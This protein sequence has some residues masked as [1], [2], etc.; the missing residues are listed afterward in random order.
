MA[1]HG[2]TPEDLEDA[3]HAG[4]IAPLYLFYGEEDYLIDEA[5]ARL[6][7]ASLPESGR[8]FNLDVLSGTDTDARDIVAR[9]SAF[10]MVAERRIVIVREA[11]RLPEKGLELLAHY[12]EKPSPS[13][14]LVL[15]AAKP[16]M[17]RRAF[18]TIKRS[19]M[20]FEFRPLYENQLPSWIERRARVRK[21][22]ITLEAAKLLVAYVG[23]SLRDL[24]NEL[25]KVFLYMGDRLAITEDDVA[26][27][28]GFTREFN[29][30]EL[31]RAIG[32][33][34]LSRA[35]EVMEKMLDANQPMPLIVSVLTNYFSTLWKIGDL[36]RR[37]TKQ[38]DLTGQVRMNPYFLKEYL[39]TLTV[40]SVDEI[41]GAFHHLAIVD[42]EY[43][44]AGADVK[45][46]VH[47]FLVRLMLP[48]KGMVEA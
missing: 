6:L 14:C 32:E 28:V 47:R 45:S 46:I 34:N 31:Q 19:G 25:E 24:D 11:E 48:V 22:T 38:A 23:S 43:K 16:D 5:V 33:R 30:F 41:E 12:V 21:G 7:K 8:A 37:G 35:V 29:V 44:T 17:R 40:Y 4:K 26:A 1:G 20:A 15:I 36:L 18:A 39:A 13:T 42:E 2:P 27:V 3:L 9:A 10:P